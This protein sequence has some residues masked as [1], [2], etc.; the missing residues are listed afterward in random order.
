MSKIF[1]SNNWATRN[2]VPD[3]IAILIEIRS[4]KFVEKYKVNKMPEKKPK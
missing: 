1:T 3:P 4:S 2:A